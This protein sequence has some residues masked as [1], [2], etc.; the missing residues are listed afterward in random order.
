MSDRESRIP[1]MGLRIRTLRTDRGMTQSEL[2]GKI[3]AAPSV[4][5]NYEAELR[6][7]SYENLIKLSEVFGVSTD[8]L[9]GYKK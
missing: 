5:G 1:G 7:P 9:L 6:A 8:Y 4:I 3:G 2:A